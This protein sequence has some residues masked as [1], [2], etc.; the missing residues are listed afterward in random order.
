M[1]SDLLVMKSSRYFS[2]YRHA[3]RSLL[4]EIE[5]NGFQNEDPGSLIGQSADV[6]LYLY[7]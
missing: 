5:F 7:Q 3:A 4:R 2:I 1:Q 6:I